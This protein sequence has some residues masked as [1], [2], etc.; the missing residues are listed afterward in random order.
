MRITPSEEPPSRIDALFRAVVDAALDAIVAID[1]SGAIRSVNRATEQI[2]GYRSAELVGRN[3]NMLMPEPYAGEH[4]GYL[5]NYLRTGQKKIIGIG[6]EVAGRRKDGSVF[7]MDL[8]VGEAEVDGERIFVG[9]IR[10]ITDRKADEAALRES[11]LR[12]RSI[13]DTVPDAIVV[14][15]E[16]GVVA[17]FSLA[18]ERLFGYAG[19]DVIGQNVSMLMP[20]PYRGA[21]DSYLARYLRTGERRIIGIGRVV[22]GLRKNGE[23]FPMELQVGQFEVGGSRFFTGFVRDLTEQQT[24]ERRIHDLQ[25]E[26][27]HTSRLSVMGQMA[28]TMA[29]ELN[30]PLTAVVNYLEA[31][32]HLLQRGP[33]AAE[34]VEGLIARAVA[35]AERAGDV[36]RQLRQFVS[37]GETDRRSQSLNQLVEEA[38]ALALVGARQSGVRVSLE[39]DHGVAPVLVDG[40]QIQQVVLNLV[41]NAVEAMEA[42]ERRQLTIATRAIDGEAMAE[43]TV[44]D[45]GPGI[46]PEIADAPVPAVRHHQ[47]GRHGA[48]PV[49]LPRDRRGASRAPERG[50]GPVRRHRVPPDRAD[51]ARRGGGRGDRGCRMS[52]S[53]MSSTMTRR[54][55]SR[56]RPCWRRRDTPCAPSRW[57]ATSSRAAPTLRPGCLIADIRM[58]EMDGLELQRQLTERK[59]HFPLIVITGHADVPLAVRAMKVGAVDFIEKPFSADAIIASLDAALARLGASGGEDPLASTAAARLVLLSPREREVLQGLLAGLPNKSI[60]YDL[61]I[62]PR[63]VEIH[64]ARVM[65]K[66]GARSL[67]EL[68]RMSLAA[69][70]QPRP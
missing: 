3:V 6:R 21:H 26:L 40:V 29:H 18:A 32:R 67:S 27:L 31:A 69:G 34:R 35:Q 37:K 25:A 9:I 58:P 64:R 10:D 63:T 33:E 47:T 45:S 62:S 50:V 59:F 56:W 49:D 23:T 52:G 8:A 48:G 43:V 54:C 70:L 36:I 44:V 30:Q 14:I 66:M 13:L 1:H 7:P 19:A 42:V 38:L 57:R 28:S 65:D 2:F 20:S 12:L 51:A 55:A 68:I 11:E 39:L 17:R 60:A 61:A 41:R 53:S 4:D 24:T 16:R 15:D 46:A 5:G 22:V